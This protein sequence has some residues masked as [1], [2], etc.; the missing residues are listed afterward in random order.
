MIE[1]TFDKLGEGIFQIVKRQLAADLVRSG[2]PSQRVLKRVEAEAI[3]I[4]KQQDHVYTGAYIEG[5]ESR[6]ESGG[7]MLWNTAPYAGSLEVGQPPGEWPDYD[8]LLGWV[9]FKLV[10]R[11]KIQPEEAPRVTDAIRHAIHDR[12][13]PPRYIVA[14]AIEDG[15]TGAPDSGWF[16]PVDW[17]FDEFRKALPARDVFG[18][19]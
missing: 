6:P 15:G 18:L 11:G 8:D 17:I 14:Q 13:L 16:G 19:E 4:A 2:T 10:E 7:A 3:R 9:N 12:G 5:F 1:V